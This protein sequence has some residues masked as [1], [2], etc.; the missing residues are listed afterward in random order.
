MK[1]HLW[2]AAAYFCSCI[3]NRE[4]QL[5]R[6]SFIC[7][8]IQLKGGSLTVITIPCPWISKDNNWKRSCIN[9]DS[10]ILTNLQL[11]EDFLNSSGKSHN[12]KCHI[13]S[14]LIIWVKFSK[15]CV[16]KMCNLQ[17]AVSGEICDCAVLLSFVY[18]SI[19][20]F[21]S[22]LTFISMVNIF[23]FDGVS[24]GWG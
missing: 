24:F 4:E 7:E 12:T 22:A 9:S 2:P 17:R 8:E 16:V 14:S 5:K 11:P 18:E 15:L 20:F 23:V 21:N 1:Q 13:C 3:E 6:Q 10:E 19:P